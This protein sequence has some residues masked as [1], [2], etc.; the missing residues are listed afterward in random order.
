MKYNQRD[1]R[2]FFDGKLSKEEAASIAKWI[3]SPEGDKELASIAEEIW[4]NET[5]DLELNPTK[6]SLDGIQMISNSVPAK[7]KPIQKNYNRSKI[8]FSMAAAAALAITFGLPFLSK[9]FN[10]HEVQNATATD[11]SQIYKATERGQRKVITLPDG[12]RVTLN[13]GSNIEYGQDFVTNRTVHLSGEAFFE[14]VKDSEHPFLVVSQNLSTTALGTSFNIKAYGD[15]SPIQVSLAT[16]KIS[17][18]NNLSPSQPIIVEPGEAVR[19]DPKLNSLKKTKIDIKGAISWQEGILN[20]EKVPF[21]EILTELERW[22][23]VEFVVKGKSSIPALKC[24]G[25]FGPNEYL[26]NVL[27]ALSHSVDFDYQIKD[28]IVLLDLNKKMPMKHP[29]TPS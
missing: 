16:G 21:Q 29:K 5:R 13:A 4:K 17:V 19:F 14:V 26:S 1:I 11:K 28:K 18:E 24:S 23:G 25:T 9:V 15:T 3:N 7:P 8:W 12:S 27:E 20:F 22:Y 2:R 10:T 6:S